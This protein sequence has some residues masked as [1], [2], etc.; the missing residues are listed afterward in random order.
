MAKR[1]MPNGATPNSVTLMKIKAISPEHQ[2]CREAGR[3]GLSWLQTAPAERL[4]FRKAH[5]EERARWAKSKGRD[6]S[7]IPAMK[8]RAPWSAALERH[9]P[10]LRHG[11]G[12]DQNRRSTCASH[13][14]KGSIGESMRRSGPEAKR[15]SSVDTPRSGEGGE[16]Q[17]RGSTPRAGSSIWP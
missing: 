14:T 2:G 15:G 4:P 16:A 8:A 3:G 7:G 17:A 12:A 1:V 11:A 6:P 5:G 13:S 10:P 9:A